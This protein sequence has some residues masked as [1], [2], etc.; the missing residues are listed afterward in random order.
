LQPTGQRLSTGKLV[1]S[2][3]IQKNSTEGYP[4][5]VYAV[6]LQTSGGEDAPSAD[7]NEA[8]YENTQVYRDRKCF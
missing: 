3:L 5:E 4:F 8:I 6:S 1:V 2:E 7:D